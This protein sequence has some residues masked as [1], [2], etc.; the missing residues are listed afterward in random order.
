MFGY[1]QLTDFSHVRHK[2][3]VTILFAFLGYLFRHL[4][5]N[6]YIVTNV[7]YLHV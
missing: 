7:R 3:S 4:S 1:V 6:D 5:I 2:K